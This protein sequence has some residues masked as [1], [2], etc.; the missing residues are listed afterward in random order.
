MIDLQDV[1]KRFTFD[2]VCKVAFGVESSTLL[3]AAGDGRRH[4]AR[5]SGRSTTPSTSP[6][7][8][9]SFHPMTVSCGRQWSLTLERVTLLV[10][11]SE[12]QDDKRGELPLSAGA[13][14][15]FESLSSQSVPEK[16]ASS[17]AAQSTG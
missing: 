13:I 14:A 16:I 9:C 11:A 10:T 5:S 1:R 12:M 2:S 7:R 3:E 4:E 17:V 8:A 15:M 6:S